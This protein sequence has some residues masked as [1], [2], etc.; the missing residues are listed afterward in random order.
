MKPEKI[1]VCRVPLRFQCSS[2]VPQILSASSKSSACVKKKDTILLFS[3]GRR[4]GE[5]TY[6]HVT[7]S[8]KVQGGENI[9]K[10]KSM[11]VY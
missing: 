6:R 5:D 10:H 7:F 1:P 4:V 3:Q 9:E 11:M 8:C 2:R